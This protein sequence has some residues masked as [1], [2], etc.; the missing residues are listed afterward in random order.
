[1]TVSISVKIQ[2]KVNKKIEKIEI[3]IEMCLTETYSRVQVG[4]YFSDMFPIKNR[5]K[6]GDA[7]IAIAFQ[8]CF[9]VYH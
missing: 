3:K 7:F 2:R 8:L 1:M 5:L 9:Q 6:Q 4:K